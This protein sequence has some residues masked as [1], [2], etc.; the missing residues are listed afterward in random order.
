MRYFHAFLA[1]CASLISLPA[2][3]NTIDPTGVNS[4]YSQASFGATP[5]DIRFRPIQEYVDPRHVNLNI[6][7]EMQDLFDTQSNGPALNLFLVN[8]ITSP[9]GGTT[10]GVTEF[11]ATGF[12]PATGMS[13]GEW[14][15]NIAYNRNF[16]GATFAPYGVAHEIGHAL[17]L[18]HETTGPIFN[19]G[20]PPDNLMNQFASSP[21][22][23]PDQVQTMLLSPF[24][25]GSASSG[26]F[27]DVNV[28]DVQSAP[29]VVPLPAGAVLLLSA[30]GSLAFMR[31]RRNL[32]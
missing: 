12:D 9:F 17:G 7:T 30:F 15:N 29:S 11:I 1:V 5:F 28:F 25:Q 8:S 23:R 19:P 27:V 10:V 3:A 20:P 2:A 16:L 18:F 32:A 24:L 26:F 21:L 6:Q 4:I 31:R 14:R 13:L 22:L